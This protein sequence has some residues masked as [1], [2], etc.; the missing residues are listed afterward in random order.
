M[1][2]LP[3]FIMHHP[4]LCAA[5][6]AV[7]VFIVVTELRRK[8]GARAITAVQAVQ[9][10]NGHEAVMVDLREPADYKAGHILNAKHVPLS[11]LA[12]EAGRVSG[13]KNR[14]VIVYDKNGMTAAS[15]CERLKAEGYQQVSYLKNG[16]YGW[17]DENLPLEK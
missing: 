4:Y 8:T 17:L 9:L 7:I 1:E 10:I 12:E 6:A 11:R 15:A 14:P 13:D 3:Q 5:L 2:K 16:I